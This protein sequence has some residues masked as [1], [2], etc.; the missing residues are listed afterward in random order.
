MKKP[1]QPFNSVIKP[2]N[3]PGGGRHEKFTPTPQTYIHPDDV[4]VDS[5]KRLPYK[6]VTLSNGVVCAPRYNP[7]NAT[8]DDVTRSFTRSYEDVL[9]H[10]EPH[11]DPQERFQ[12]RPSFQRPAD[13]EPTVSFANDQKKITFNSEPSQAEKRQATPVNPAEKISRR[14]IV[15]GQ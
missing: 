11:G 1:Q 13:P 5:V 10:P 14:K 12:R 15:G 8:L 9:N 6:K 7:P 3:T 4:H 2:L